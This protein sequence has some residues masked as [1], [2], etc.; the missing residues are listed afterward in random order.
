MGGGQSRKGFSESTNSFQGVKQ[1]PIKKT[2][3]ILIFNSLCIVQQ[4]LTMYKSLFFRH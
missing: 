4:I 3:H 2:H 1:I